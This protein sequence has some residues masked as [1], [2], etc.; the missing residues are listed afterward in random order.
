MASQLSSK[1][2]SWNII[3]E[4]LRKVFQDFFKNSIINASINETYI[5]LIP[6]KVDAKRVNDYKP[7]SLTTCL[8]K[9]V[10][11]VLFERLKR[12]LP[13]TVIEYQSPV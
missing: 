2:K 1:K 5:Y 13:S 11:Q 12:V 8:Y 10:A 3:K 4:D 6:K 9:V 7:I